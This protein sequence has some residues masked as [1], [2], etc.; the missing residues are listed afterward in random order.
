MDL[1]YSSI[2]TCAVRAPSA[3]LPSD[4]DNNNN[5][6]EFQGKKEDMYSENRRDTKGSYK[7][8]EYNI[9]LI[10][11]VY[12]WKSSPSPRLRISVYK[13]QRLQ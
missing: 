12:E 10:V 6:D 5:D 7:S 11:S 8:K 3:F 13:L 2:H 9:R 1:G 4:P